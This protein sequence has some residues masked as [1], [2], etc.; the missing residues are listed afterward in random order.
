MDKEGVAKAKQCY[1]G[2]RF[3]WERGISVED[4]ALQT[5]LDASAIK[6]VLGLNRK[7]FCHFVTGNKPNISGVDNEAKRNNA[8]AGT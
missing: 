2:L 3:W 6:E 4:M 5:G 7:R 8:E 1:T